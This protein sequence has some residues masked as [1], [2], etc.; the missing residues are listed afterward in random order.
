MPCRAF[1]VSPHIV[2]Y[3]VD[4]KMDESQCPVGHSSFL[5]SPRAYRGGKHANVSMPCRAFFAPPSW[6]AKRVTSLDLGLR[7]P[8]TWL[9][10]AALP[11]RQGLG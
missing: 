5:H 11:L 9:L 1:F 8:F 4:K 3:E 7:S 10:F 6:V 2:D